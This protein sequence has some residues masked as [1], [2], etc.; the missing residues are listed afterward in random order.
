MAEEAKKPAPKRK[1]KGGKKAGES[2]RKPRPPRLNVSRQ[3]AMIELGRGKSIVAAA[4]A[5]GVDEKT[6]RTYL[7]DPE[8]QA[9]LKPL[10]EESVR[11]AT[12]QLDGCLADVMETAIRIALG[13][14]KGSPWQ[15]AMIRDVLNRRKIGSGERIEVEGEFAGMTNEQ[16]EKIAR[17]EG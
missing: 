12:Q 7:K 10:I 4:K 1:R 8:F 3:V 14:A 2:A 5:A 15:V 9:E 11:L 16:L 6:V 17:G 13:E